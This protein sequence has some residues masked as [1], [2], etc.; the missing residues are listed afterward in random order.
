MIYYL[1]AWPEAHL[2]LVTFGQ[3]LLPGA[4]LTASGDR[5]IPIFLSASGLRGTY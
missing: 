4:R 3:Y 2:R 5:L 1:L